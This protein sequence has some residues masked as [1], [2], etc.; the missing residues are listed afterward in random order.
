MVVVVGFTVT[1]TPLVAAR[2]PGVM[3]PVPFWNTPVSVALVPSVMEVGFAVKLVMLAGGGGGGGGALD[4]LLQPLKPVGPRLT[5][6]ANGAR[7]RR[8]FM[9]FPM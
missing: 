7:R 4:A 8:R 5:A 1:A 2:L 3:T 9:R 6:T